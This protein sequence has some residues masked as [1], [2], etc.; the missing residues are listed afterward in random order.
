MTKISNFNYPGKSELP[1]SP[2]P[3]KAMR[4]NNIPVPQIKTLENKFQVMNNDSHYH[5][6]S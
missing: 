1:P 5:K 2:L 4:S 6:E 3:H